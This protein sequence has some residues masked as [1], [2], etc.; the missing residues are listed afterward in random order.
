MKMS[1]ENLKSDFIEFGF[2]LNEYKEILEKNKNTDKDFSPKLSF[3]FLHDSIGKF[4]SLHVHEN[5]GKRCE[6]EGTLMD[7]RNAL[8]KMEDWNITLEKDYKKIG[9][10]SLEERKLKI[11]KFRE[12]QQRRR[13]KVPLN[14]KYDGRRRVA[15]EKY[16]LNGKFALKPQTQVGK[17]ILDTCS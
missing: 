1:L 7:G 8:I 10:Y 13:M 9:K 16:R 11:K 2:H 17:D 15:F 6:K 14:K 4:N 3:D 5:T 12:K